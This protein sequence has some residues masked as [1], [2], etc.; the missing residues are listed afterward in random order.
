VHYKYEAF[1]QDLCVNKVSRDDELQGDYCERYFQSLKQIEELHCIKISR[2]FFKKGRPVKSIE[3]HSFSD[4]SEKAH[5]CVVHLRICHESG[6]T[7]VR[8]VTSKAKMNPIKK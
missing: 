8:F 5:A 2:C 3:I 1:V 7:E 6:E 4:A